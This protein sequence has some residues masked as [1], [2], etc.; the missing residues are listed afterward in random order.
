MGGG[1]RGWVNK[2][3]LSRQG[4]KTYEGDSMAPSEEFSCRIQSSIEFQGF[5]C[6]GHS[7]EKDR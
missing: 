1:S 3:A 2:G 5:L 7:L 6:W 4:L